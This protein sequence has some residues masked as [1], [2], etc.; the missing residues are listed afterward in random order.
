MVERLK[1]RQL[2]HFPLCPFSR[3]VRVVL[4][5]KKLDATLIYEPVWK[6]RAEF[7]LYNPAGTVPVL[8][9]NILTDPRKPPQEH[10]LAHSEAICQYLDEAYSERS[11]MGSDYFFRAEVNRLIGWFD[12][13]FFLEVSGPL[14]YEK[15]FKRLIGQG[16]PDSSRLRK[17]LGL[18][19]SH[20]T[21]INTLVRDRYWLAGDA[22]SIADIA[23]AAHLS[24]IDY[25]GNVQWD[26][27]KEAK[28]WYAR[29]KCRPSFR[30]LL[31][32]RLPGLPPAAIYE[33]LDF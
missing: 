27:Y 4:G 1:M 5:E 2:Y 13:K 15:V 20:L 8:I 19:E 29:L 24:T 32:D 23:A 22:F 3:K 17:A 25:F 28:E 14:L 10:V 9:E 6:R 26:Q 30:G 7:L 11:L 18:I 16:G 33:D 31:S 12:E 21:Y